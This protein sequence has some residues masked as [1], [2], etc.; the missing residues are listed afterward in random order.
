MIFMDSMKLFLIVP[1][2]FHLSPA[3]TEKTPSKQR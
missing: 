2:R 1:D 3:K